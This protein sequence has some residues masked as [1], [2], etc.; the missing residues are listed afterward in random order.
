MKKNNKGRKIDFGF[1]FSESIE[2]LQAKL[3]LPSESQMRNFLSRT[4]DAATEKS[5]GISPWR[6]VPVYIIFALVFIIL[7]ARAFQLQIIEGSNF[8][9]KS[10]G[11]HVLIK[12]NHAPRGVIYDR[13][14]KVLVRN[15]PG[16]RLA[17]RRI[18]LPKNW[19]KQVDLL[20]KLLGKDSQDLINTINKSKT[21]SVTIAQDL[22]N[23]QI[24]TLKTSEDN[25]SWLDIELNPK[26][27]YVYGSALAAVL[28]YTRETSEQDL[29]RKD[30]AAYSAGDQVGKAGI[31]ES[32][33]NELRGSNGFQLLKVDSQGKKQGVLFE[34][35]AV[36]GGDVTL[37]IDAQLQ[38]FVYDNLLQVLKDKGGTGASAVVEDPFSGEILA[39]VSVPTFD[40]NLF[41]KPLTS[42]EYS[43]LV[44]DP[45]Y[46]LLNRAI[47]SSYPPGSTFKLV[48]AAA[49]LETG[50]ITKDTKIND[51]GFFTL[52]DVTFNN[53]LWTDHHQTEGEISIVRAISRSNDT[54]FYN[55]GYRLGVDNISKYSQEFGLGKKTGIE[56]AGE[57]AGLVPSRDWKEKTFNQI[58]FPGETINYSIGQG[59]LLISP[60]QL[61]QI[62]TFFAN[63]G[64]L[65]KP[66]L[67]HSS[68]LNVVSEDLVKP[69]N[70]AIVQEGMYQNTVGDGNVAYLF[71]NYNVKTA[72]KTGSAESGGENKAHSWYTGYGPIDKPQLAIT[73]MVERAGHGSEISAPLTKKIFE[74]WFTNR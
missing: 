38:Q 53:W 71:K 49:G 3:T 16:F 74:W 26:R 36:A 5:L 29:A 63:G 15:T 7:G 20:A 24:I 48:M 19:Q 42:E 50:T 52:G 35:K 46:L 41:S 58:W 61:N 25:F 22:S 1:S 69:E 64:K 45:G 4:Q 30:V 62:T 68:I 33:E 2:G 51:T 8:L 65:I 56:L 43:N 31:E 28:G 6:L 9:N 18:D 73:V 17:V 70:I 37:S 27:D 40:N 34:T 72:G 10:E 14:G 32:F 13:N 59:Y 54:F 44:N 23:E 67:I 57:T 39:L 66:T 55:L 60:L 11:N 21:E 12:I 47:G